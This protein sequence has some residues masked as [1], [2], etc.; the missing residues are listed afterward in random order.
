MMTLIYFASLIL[1]SAYAWERY[2]V[3]C[4][5]VTAAVMVANFVGMTLLELH[6]SAHH[7]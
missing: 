2:G 3:A 7:D 5:M 4:G 6:R 1:A